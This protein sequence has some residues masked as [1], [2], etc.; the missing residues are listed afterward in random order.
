[1]TTMD[2]FRTAQNSA[3]RIIATF[4]EGQANKP[5]ALAART[6]E[7]SK[8]KKDELV[9]MIIGLE[10]KPV[11]AKPKVEDIVKAL[12]VDEDCAI[13]PYESIAQLVHQAI[14]EANTSS[15]SVASY[16]SKKGEDWGAKKRVKLHLDPLEVMQAQQAA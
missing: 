7:L 16:F 10:K 6:E 11:D 2:K 9:A 5:D 14:P 3:N 13:L 8:M 12:L 15:K 4:V 1:M